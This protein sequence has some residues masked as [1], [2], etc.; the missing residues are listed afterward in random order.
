MKKD[1]TRPILQQ[2]QIECLEYWLCSKLK[3][4]LDYG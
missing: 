2:I 4:C 1:R 3:V